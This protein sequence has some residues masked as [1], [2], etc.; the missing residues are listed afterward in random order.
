MGGL[1]LES[2]RRGMPQSLPVCSAAWKI[3]SSAQDV[4]C[5][6]APVAAVMPGRGQLRLL[7]AVAAWRAALPSFRLPINLRSSWGCIDRCT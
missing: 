4:V 1:G 3:L 7:T 2:G 5:A 6:G